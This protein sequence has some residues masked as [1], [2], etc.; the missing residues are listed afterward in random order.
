M[1]K[2]GV[3]GGGFLGHHGQFTASFGETHQ[4]KLHSGKMHLSYRKIKQQSQDIYIII[5]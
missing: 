3:E 1:L 2:I 4:R 5:N